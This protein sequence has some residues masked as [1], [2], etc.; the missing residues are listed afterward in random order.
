[1]AKKTK[2]TK[3][4]YLAFVGQSILSY[5]GFLLSFQLYGLL[6][7]RF[8]V[9]DLAIASLLCRKWRYAY[10]AAA[11]KMSCGEIKMVKLN[12]GIVTTKKADE[13]TQRVLFYIGMT[14]LT[15]SLFCTAL[16]NSALGTNLSNLSLASGYVSHDIHYETPRSIQVGYFDVPCPGVRGMARIME[17]QYEE[18]V[19]DITTYSAQVTERFYNIT[20]YISD[21]TVYYEAG[22]SSCS[23][24]SAPQGYS[25]DQNY[26]VDPMPDLHMKAGFVEKTYSCSCCPSNDAREGECEY[27]YNSCNM[28]PPTVTHVST[29]TGE[30]SFDFKLECQGNKKLKTLQITG[31]LFLRST[32]EIDPTD[33]KINDQS[34]AE[35][36]TPNVYHSALYY[37][38]G[39][40]R[41]DVL[42]TGNK[43]C[44]DIVNVTPSFSKG[45]GQLIVSDITAVYAKCDT[46][47]T[48]FS[49][50]STTID[51]A[52]GGTVDLI[53]SI[54]DSSGNPAS[55]RVN[56]AGKTY[57][58]SG[59]DVS[60]TWD[61]K[62]PDGTVVDPGSYTA[63]LEAWLTDDP[64]CAD[65]KTINFTV[66]ES[67]NC[68]L[69]VN[70][71]SS[72]NVASGNL[73][74]SQTLFS[75]KGSGLSASMIL[76]YNSLDPY[77]GPLGRG[78]THNYDITLKETSDGSVIL[79]EGVGARSLYKKNG[80]GYTSQP[81]DHSLLTRNADGAF[82]LTHKDGANYN[83]G[84][85][86]KIAAITDRNGNAVT[87]GYTNGNLTSIIDPAGRATTIS[88][89]TASHITSVTDPS[90]NVNSFTVT[91]N[92][93]TSVAYPGGGTWSYTYDADAFMRTKTDPNGN[94]TTY[95]YDDQHRVTSSL[96]DGNTRLI[97]YPTGTGTTKTTTFTETDGG[98][99]QYTYD[100]QA[101]MLTQKTDPQGGVTSYTYDSNRNMLAK[102]DP[103]GSATGYAYDASGNMTSTTDALGQT[104]SYTYN[105]FGQVTA[106]IDPQGN[107]TANAYDEKGNLISTTDATGATTSYEY[108]AQGHVTK[109]T[110]PAGQATTFTYDQSG[111]LASVTDPTGATTSFTY[112]AAGNVTSQT[113]ANGNTTRFEYDSNNH[114][115]KVTDPAGNVTIFGYDKNGNR[116]SQTDASGNVT[117]FEYNAKGQL[118]KAIDALGNITTYTY[119][120]TGCPSCGGGGDKLTSVSDA[121]GHATTYEYNTLGRLIKETDPLGNSI[122]YSYDAKGNITSRTDA[123]GNSISY[124]YD[125]RGRLF[126]KIYPDSTTTSFTYDA[127]GNILTASNAAIAY[128]LTSDASGRVTSI[129]DANSRTVGYQYNVLGNK[130]KTTYPDGSVVSYN[131]DNS[132]RLTSIVNGG[133]RT[134]SYQYDTLGRRTMLTYP[135]GVTT[136]YAY[137]NAGRLTSL[138]TQNSAHQTLN[139]YTYTLDKVGNRL[140]KTEPDIKYTYGYD[141]IYQLLQSLPVKPHGREKEDGNEQGGEHKA[142]IFSY[143]P[144]GNRQNGPRTKDIYNYNEGNQLTSD[145]KHQYEFDKNGNLT[146][147]IEKDD[148]EKATVWTYTYDYENRLTKVEKSED[149]ETLRVSFKYDPFGRRIEKKVEEVE[150]G[151]AEE[152]KTFTYVYD[153][154]DI[155]LEYQAKTDDGKPKTDTTRYIH[156]PGIDELL[157]LERKGEMYYYHA[158]G[159]GSVT[160][161]TDKKQKVVESYAYSSFGEIK[162]NGD[163]VKN[164]FTFTSRE[165]DE[166]IGLYYYRARYYDAKVGRFIESDPIGLKGGI[167]LYVYAE[168]NPI[169]FTDPRG[170]A[171]W[172][173]SQQ[174]QLPG[175]WLAHQMGWDHQWLKTN[176]VEAGYGPP[177]GPEGSPMLGDPVT[178]RN[179]AGRSAQPGA[180]CVEKRCVDEACVNRV[181]S[182]L[183]GHSLGTWGPYNNCNT[184]VSTVL[185]ACRL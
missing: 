153:N 55:W 10:C 94:T 101:G 19:H 78:W 39:T 88:Y 105:T 143:D 99:W 21:Y 4:P 145:S 108:D 135:N 52:A 38:Q 149:N 47:I 157:A 45:Y 42:I 118:I 169:R 41:W 166:E 128:T 156:G 24:C 110:N 53:G 148:D 66:E 180:R 154:E 91:N 12:N 97:S 185:E 7:P 81:G 60:V 181:L 8:I 5:R 89:D 146:K 57:T 115:I 103:D 93:L 119:G 139:S 123:N 106:I 43:T 122:T 73:F 83:F 37:W 44:G 121:N 161:L 62:N 2:T 20:G 177:N 79:R 67:D 124:S 18:D 160:A 85:N 125:S 136:S 32:A 40:V 68:S 9:S 129:T 132:G 152:T 98:V 31:N 102:T 184:F 77:A 84:Q 159:L 168:N 87:F 75:T 130:K 11:P 100:T 80:S 134:Y 120:G 51:P 16:L 76:H 112:D 82:A 48:A 46:K 158:D 74:H 140:T 14:F 176:S 50:S 150:H 165:W 13:A 178:V 64:T 164:A 25:W 114:L 61:G 72:A 63:T 142:E 96:V 56:V 22:Q 109:V 95:S 162:Q 58:G 69:S 151:R 126:K 90:G 163:K 167:N 15:V 30:T 28:Q 172:V 174:A 147:K 26:N 3:R 175:G 127:K 1:M 131:Y 92:T 29:E 183:M 155:I 173:C 111:N 116:T 117:R 23:S 137:D 138:F 59:T 107:T 35:H 104:T 133:G 27:S 34:L 49:G 6:C 170:L 86:G 33:L 17:Y 70:F 144:V 141:T 182:G 113:D 36:G 71:G 179:H 65:S 54:S 171:V